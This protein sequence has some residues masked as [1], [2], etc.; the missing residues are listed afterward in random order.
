MNQVF[1]TITTIFVFLVLNLTRL[2]AFGQLS[3]GGVPRTVALAMAPDTRDDFVLEAPDLALVADQDRLN[4]VP[5][6]FAVTLPADIDFKNSGSR[7]TAM[8]GS[9]VWR[10]N[11]HAPGA[12]ALTLYFDRFRLPEGGRLF[13]YNST[14]TQILGAFT[15]SNNNEFNTF[16]TSL[17]QGERLTLEYNAP[18]NLPAPEIHISEVAYAYRGVA[19]PR[20]KTG[21]GSAGACEVNVNCSEGA[22]SQGPKRGVV[23]I[24]V[25]V[26]ASVT[27]CTGS[28][29]NNARNDKTPYVLT[30]DH[31]GKYSSAADMNQWIFYFNY[32]TPGCP[33]PPVE[34][35]SNSMTGAQMKAHANVSGSDFFLVLL[36]QPIPDLYNVFYNGW[37][38]ENIPSPSGVGIH[39]PQGD[40]KKIST[41]TTPLTSASWGGSPLSYWKVTWA[42]TANGHG[43]TEGG[44]SGSPIFDNDDYLIGTLTGGDSQCN[45][46]SLNLP[47]YYGKFSYH[48]DKNGTDSAQVLKYWLDPDSTGVTKLYGK[49]VGV[50]E[51]HPGG[52]VTIYP[53]PFTDKIQLN[54]A[55]VTGMIRVRIMDIWGKSL[56]SRELT[57]D[58]NSPFT[59][60]LA[61]FAPGV[62][63]VILTGD[64]WQTTR[65]IIKQ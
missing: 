65:K 49:M 60:D 19:D 6:R 45:T 12:L 57:G 10:L 32:E 27:W 54:L 31:C 51:E 47:D 17:I 23:R 46:S 18:D 36:N 58:L 5:Y 28:V 63:L 11:I 25:K 1:L 20:L 61:G 29:L 4:P 59:L 52:T 55:G 7:T 15:S 53:N 62:Y 64:E 38:R 24:E 3:Q 22:G 50:E 39:H 35:T 41:Y 13:V 26:G 33:N 43:V 34:P 2:S 14:R 9:Q 56:F 21:F 44:S 40:I 48:W 37:S 42:E 8:D 16:A 30:A